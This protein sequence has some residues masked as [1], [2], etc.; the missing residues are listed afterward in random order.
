MFTWFECT[1]DLD[2]KSFSSGTGDGLGRMSEF[3]VLVVNVFLCDF[4]ADC[5]LFLCISH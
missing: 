2:G 3:K 1:D 5:T 4:V